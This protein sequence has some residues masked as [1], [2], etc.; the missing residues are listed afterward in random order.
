M[1]KTREEKAK[2]IK[3][4]KEGLKG[5]SNLIFTDFSG[6]STSEIRTLR[7]TL[8]EADVKFQVIKKRLLKIILDGE[9]IEFDPKQFDGQIGTV[10][11]K[12][13][14]SEVA[15]SLYRFSKKNESFQILGGLDLEKKEELTGDTIK[16]IG[17]LPSR[18]VLLGQVLG[19][20]IAPLR[21]FMW[22]LSER[23]KQ[24]ESNK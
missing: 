18:E 12:G 15:G 3:E 10:F 17:Q 5:S 22:I 20:M 9:G 23:S 24:P 11:V 19:T 8:K 21:A 16:T 14:I 6:T 7:K 4:G 13:D 1:A 2:A